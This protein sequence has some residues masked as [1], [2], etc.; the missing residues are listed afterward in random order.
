[1]N[2]AFLLSLFYCSLQFCCVVVVCFFLRFGAS[3][4]LR[5]K[6][7]SSRVSHCIACT[8]TSRLTRSTHNHVQV[9]KSDVERVLN[10]WEKRREL[11]FKFEC[12]FVSLLTLSANKHTAQR[13]ARDLATFRLSEMPPQTSGRHTENILQL[14]CEH[15]GCNRWFKTSGGR[16]KHR[17][18]AHPTTTNHQWDRNPPPSRS[19]PPN[20]SSEPLR[21]PSLSPGPPQDGNEDENGLDQ[22]WQH[23]ELRMGGSLRRVFHPYLNGTKVVSFST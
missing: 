10:I 18:A 16:T 20:P 13:V 8:G 15:H 12:P 5:R 7:N 1:M 11:Q 23:E 6:N 21:L 3:F 22:Q 2:D 19:P 9:L 4:T 17:L 14:P